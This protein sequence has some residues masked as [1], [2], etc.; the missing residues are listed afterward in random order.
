VVAPLKLNRQKVVA[1]RKSFGEAA[2]ADPVA[3]VLVH[4]PVSFLEDIFDYLI[5]TELS[6]QII[7]GTVVKIEFG[8]G[9]TEGLVMSRDNQ[10][11]KKLKFIEG[12]IGWPG[13]I[14]LEL[15][16]HLKRVQDRFGGP[17]WSLIDSY[18]PAIPKKFSEEIVSTVVSGSHTTKIDYKFLNE[19]DMRLL[20]KEHGLRFAVNQPGGLPPYEALFALIELRK[21]LGQVL[22]IASDFREFD[23]LSAELSARFGADLSLHDTRMGKLERFKQFQRI[24]QSQPKIIL[25]NRSSVFTSLKK[26][27]SVFVLN[28]GDQSHYEIR[29]P[30]WN[31]RDVT[32]LRSIDTSL[33]F[34]SATPS[35][36]IQRLIDLK[37][38]NKLDIDVKTNLNFLVSDGQDSYIPF[39]KKALL[40]GN[41]LI[42]VASKGYAN[43]FLCGKCRNL[44][45]CKCGGKLRITA[46]GSAPSCY[47][48][49]ELQKD[50]RCVVCGESKPYVISKG[51]DRKAEEIARAIPKT[52]VI[53]F[54]ADHEPIIQSDINQIIISSRGCEPM[55][56]YAGVIL[57]DGEQLFNQP[58]LRAEET[59]KQSWFDLISR[60]I[61]GGYVYISLTNNHPLT[62]QILMRRESNSSALA[63]RKES[64]LPPFYRICEV[65]GESSTLSTFAENM[66]K[67]EKFIVSGPI[68]MERDRAKLVIRVDVD[69]GSEL[70]EVMKD[71]VKMQA[72]KGKPPFEYRFDKY[73]F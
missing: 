18:L 54:S 47:L 48:C 64:R 72:V 68:S 7:P 4:T 15:I 42:S 53:K 61:D 46:K 66:R 37:W 24:N 29:S 51:L 57:L 23:Y 55:I 43:I 50:W 49:N 2:L 8:S 36:E 70:V 26:N 52:K 21:N 41:V 44:A 45:S 25:G 11:K 59:L 28:D 71:V 73:E 35:Y 13:M 62:Q 12:V 39:V 32:L 69:H 65:S 5:P 9:I 67:F 33:F 58:S 34:F 30:G 20:Q 31:S 22:I 1:K 16:D 17:L 56:N 40:K 10:E 38:I 60:V 19:S 6:D 63:S 14:N 3:K 27:S